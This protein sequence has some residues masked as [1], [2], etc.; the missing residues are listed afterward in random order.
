MRPVVRS[1]K[2]VGFKRTSDSRGT[3]ACGFK[4]LYSAAE[5][6]GILGISQYRVVQLVEAHDV[7]TYRIG[8]N[9]FIP[10]SEVETKLQAA[11]E[12]ILSY[13]RNR[14]EVD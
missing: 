3:P 7:L 1:K 14:K 9:L 10:L 5:L 11:W 8:R 6:G 4:V 13:E 2:A 12:S